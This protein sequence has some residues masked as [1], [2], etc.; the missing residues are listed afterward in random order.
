MYVLLDKS[1]CKPVIYALYAVYA[2]YPALTFMPVTIHFLY[3]QDAKRPLC[4]V[5]DHQIFHISDKCSGTFL[6][7]RSLNQ[8]KSPESN[9]DSLNSGGK[10]MMELVAASSYL[11]ICTILL[12]GASAGVDHDRAHC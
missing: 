5:L 8:A 10:I 2:D 6:F 3:Y 1:A 4:L 11:V 12:E 9:G 7:H